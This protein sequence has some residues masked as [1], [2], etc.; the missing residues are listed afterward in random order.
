LYVCV[1]FGL[2][3]LIAQVLKVQTK[4]TLWRL[5]LVESVGLVVP[6]SVCLCC[7]VCAQFGVAGLIA[8][9]MKVQTKVILRRLSLVAR[10]DLVVPRSVCLCCDVCVCAV[11][12]SGINCTGTEG[13]DGGNI[14]ETVTGGE[15][16]LSCA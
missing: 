14:M 1:R 8:Q 11:W 15:G 13:T 12:C 5:S 3:G 2:A 4:V 9:V 10:V 6:R 7:V 16:G